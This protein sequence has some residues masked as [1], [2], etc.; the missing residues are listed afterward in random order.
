MSQSG[1]MSGTAMAA[2]VARGRSRSTGRRG[3]A[4]MD[5]SRRSAE[6]GIPEYA[7][8]VTLERARGS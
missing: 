5:R 7:A 2:P 1:E 8:V 4:L 3:K 6:S